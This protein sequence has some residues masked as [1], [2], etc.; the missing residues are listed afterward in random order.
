MER[1]AI[2]RPRPLEGRVAL[3]TGVSRR[4]GIGFAIAARLAECGADLFVQSW[5]PYDASQPWGADPGGLGEVLAALRASGRRV[6]HASADFTDPAAPERL[7]AA[8]HEAL[9]AVD[10]LVA[11]HAYST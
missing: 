5:E 3:V 4:R 8:A 11:N 9:G 1:L 10:I 7:V 2:T 6:E